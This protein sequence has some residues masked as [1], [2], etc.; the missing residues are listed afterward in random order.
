[1]SLIN[2]M[3]RDLS[4]RQPAP[5]DVMT[6]IQLPNEPR[7]RGGVLRRLALLVV[8]VVAFTAGLWFVFGPKPVRIPQPRGMPA[9]ATTAT[10]APAATPPAAAPAAAAPSAA[11]EGAAS[12]QL[13]IAT[14]LEEVPAKPAARK[15]RA[16]RAPAERASETAREPVAAPAGGGAAAGS[17][18]ASA[19]ELYA[20]ARRALDRGDDA[21][22]EPLLGQALALDPKLHSA[23]EDLA[24]LRIRQNRLDDAETTIRGGLDLDPSRPGYRKLVARVE[25]ARNRPANAVA[26]L[27]RE[28]P[29]LERDLE[30]YG[31]LAS[32]YQRV[33]RHDAATRLYRELMRLEPHEAS[34]WAGYAMSRDA[35]GDVAGALVAYSQARQLGG[36]PPNVVEHINR[37]TAALQAAR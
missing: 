29:T 33:G 27:E 21:A 19:E 36:L 22:A 7:A 31:L 10:A 18:A 16:T 25:L 23:R 8:L 20:Q 12:P 15:P 30:H 26:V 35:V 5:G 1:M 37:R 32:A 28:P 11:A 14:Q 6:G 17:G 34:W 13:Q 9:G 3:L 2:R 24:N 4:S